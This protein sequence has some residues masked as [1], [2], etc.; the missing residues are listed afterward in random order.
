[1]RADYPGPTA[2]AR[3]IE[4]VAKRVAGL[5]EQLKEELALYAQ[6]QAYIKASRK[7]ERILSERSSLSTDMMKKQAAV[8][9][10]ARLIERDLA[11]YA[12]TEAKLRAILENR[13]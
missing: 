13:Q 6:C 10:N 12:D 5:V 1:V 8:A 2:S 4:L 3:W 7:C 9:A 11:E